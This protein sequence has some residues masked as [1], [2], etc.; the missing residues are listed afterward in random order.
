MDRATALASSVSTVN[1]AVERDLR[2]TTSSSV[3]VPSV[4]ETIS[5]LPLGLIDGRTHYDITPDGRRFLLRQPVGAQAGASATIV[6]NWT[7]RLKK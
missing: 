5:T 4:M 1:G 6:M 7:E 3:S 2:R